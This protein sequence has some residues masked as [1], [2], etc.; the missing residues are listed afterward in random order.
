MTMFERRIIG[1]AVTAA[2]IAMAVALLLV[3]YSQ[4]HGEWWNA[5]VKLAVLGGIT[6][7]V[8]GINVQAL[9][10]HSGKNWRYPELVAVQV[11]AAISGAWLVALGYGTRTDTLARIGT[12]LAFIGAILFLANLMLLFTQP[13]ARPPRIP[14]QERTHQQ[15]VDRLA[16]PFTMM[17]GMVVVLATGLGVVLEYWQPTQ[18][19][20]DLVWA[21]LMLI[22]FFFAMASGTS[23][24][25]L[26][27]WAE[28]EYTSLRLIIFQIFTFLIG[29]PAMTIALGWDIDWLFRIGA[30]CTA[31]AMLCWL[32]NILPV[33]WHLPPAV[34]TG[35][36][37]ALLFMVA[38]VG[39]G[40]AFA[41]DESLG[42]RL[43][44]THVVANLFGFAGLLISG[45]GY[46]YVP[47]LADT[48]EMRWP[49]LCAPQIA[50][51]TVGCA[52][53]M[54]F[55][56]LRMY[57]QISAELVLWPCL[58]GAVGMLLFAANTAATF[59]DPEPVQSENL[60]VH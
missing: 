18:G 52:F 5:A 30:I 42:A 51:V 46:R 34:R 35:I 6:V 26:G 25:M 12:I 55:V 13:G 56:G 53:G 11:A 31:T 57:G 15:K 3:G 49:R 40:V 54:L 24:H 36:A 17:S 59:T 48:A 47:Q 37:I 10:A 58:I 4:T 8:Y 20:W 27:R 38:G 1:I 50:L 7:M 9:P 60:V 41:I 19:R 28:R 44:S 45:F 22:G 39:M 2:P 23:Y 43:R 29:L 21:H 32:L 16:I 14:W 33:A